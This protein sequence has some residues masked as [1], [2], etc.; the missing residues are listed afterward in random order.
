MGALVKKVLLIEDD[1]SI[2]EIIQEI[3]EGEGYDVHSVSNGQEG[4]DYLRS[5]TKLPALIL[6]DLMMPIKDGFAF[7]AEQVEDPQLK[8]IPV[9]VMSADGNINEKKVRTSATAYLR[10]P[11]ELSDVVD[12]VRHYCKAD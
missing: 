6:L 10:K 3:L 5:G 11:V 2:R 12:A 4:L 1:L 8:D 7:R 9:I